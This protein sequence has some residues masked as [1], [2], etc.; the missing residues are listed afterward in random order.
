MG[1][2]DLLKNLKAVGSREWLVDANTECGRVILRVLG[3]AT[4]V[5][6]SNVQPVEVF[7]EARLAFFMINLIGSFHG[8]FL[9]E[10]SKM[11]TN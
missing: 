11:S 8:Y 2:D 7:L 5:K 3:D 1:L 9:L 6:P 4:L 10:S